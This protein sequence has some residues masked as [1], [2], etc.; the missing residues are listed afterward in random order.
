MFGVLIL[1]TWIITIIWMY[2]ELKN[3]TEVDD[4]YDV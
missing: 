3:A 1:I 2:G 4:S